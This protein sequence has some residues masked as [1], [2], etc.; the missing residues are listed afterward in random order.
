[1]PTALLHK[2]SLDL[3]MSLRT[4]TGCICVG[5]LFMHG[6]VLHLCMMGWRILLLSCIYPLCGECSISNGRRKSYPAQHKLLCT[7]VNTRLLRDTHVRLSRNFLI[8][9]LFN[10]I[11]IHVRSLV[12]DDPEALP[13]STMVMWTSTSAARW[14]FKSYTVGYAMRLSSFSKITRLCGQFRTWRSQRTLNPIQ[15]FFCMYN[16]ILTQGP[17]ASD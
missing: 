9:D 1:M 11:L 15:D 3:G 5:F 8:G 7:T 4:F 16:R 6:P 17:F 10:L 2:Y 13:H 14:F 12:L